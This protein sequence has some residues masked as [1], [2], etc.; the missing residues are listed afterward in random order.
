[1]VR[2]A[3]AV[4]I[5]LFLVAGLA[6]AADKEVKGKV[7]KVDAK[8]MTITVQ[9]EDGKKEFDVG[10]DTKFL[11]P[12]GGVSQKGIEDDRLVPGAEVTIKLAGN[13]KTIHEISLPERKGKDKP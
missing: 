4:L 5:A 8:K 1:M 9:T 11:G 3:M 6:W 12:R 13:N 10:K 2:H 7:V